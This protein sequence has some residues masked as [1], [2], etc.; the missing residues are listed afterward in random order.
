MALLDSPLSSVQLRAPPK[1]FQTLLGVRLDEFDALFEKIAAAALAQQQARHG[2]WTP[3][4]VARLVH[5]YR[6]TLR[7]HLCITLLYL[8]QY[9]LQDVLAASFHVSQA[10]ISR[11]VKR[12]R[13][14][15]AQVLPTSSVTVEAL[16][17]WVHALPAALRHA[18]AATVI[19]DASE[20]RIDR[21][22]DPAQQKQDYSG[23]KNV[24]VARCN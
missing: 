2:L 10:H 16:Q 8:R 24:T 11:I 21:S 9:P 13:P 6:A 15:L 19:I 17:G 12:L 3:E 5:T 18:Y 7:E 22:L 14:L 4:R 1:R 20:Q 23:K